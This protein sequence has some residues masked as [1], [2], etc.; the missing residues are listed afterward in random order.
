MEST[1]DQS[2]ASDT[3][4]T[5][6]VSQ[7]GKVRRMALQLKGLLDDFRTWIDLRL[8][9]AI[10]KVEER[11]DELRNEIVLGLTVAVAGFFAA[12]FSLATLALGVGWLLGHPFWGFLAVSVALLL[13][14]SLLRMT[15][16]SLVP[17]VDLL[18]RLR[19]KKYEGT[20][21]GEGGRETERRSQESA[22]SRSSPTSSDE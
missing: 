6:Q 12:I 17:P 14:V 1:E 9:L 3:N 7:D 5:E 21:N 13:I 8:D 10:L 20:Q 2:S 16:P 22:A 18:R 19:G 15:Q 4:R 11:I